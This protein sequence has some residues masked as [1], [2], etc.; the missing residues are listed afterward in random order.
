MAERVGL[1]GESF[2]R[3][4]TT[5]VKGRGRSLVEQPNYDCVFYDSKR[6]CTVYE[7]RPQQCRTWP[8]WRP[9][10]ASPEAWAEESE[11]C[12]GMNNGPRYDADHVISTA[13]ND[14]LP[15]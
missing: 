9:L 14:G 8:F 4:Y 6:G 3:R 1:D 5:V 15:G 11:D 2:R 7:D 13:A 12:P 10:I